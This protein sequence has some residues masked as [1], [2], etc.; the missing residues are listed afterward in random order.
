MI[1]PRCPECLSPEIEPDRASDVGRWH[2]RNCGGRFD[3]EFAFVRLREAVDFRS[4]L[5]SEPAFHLH[6]ALA[7][8]ELRALDGTIRALSPYS[9]AGELHRVL[10]AA[11]ATGVIEPLRV[12]ATL[13]AYLFPGPEPHPVLGVALGVGAELVGPEPALR[14]EE[15]EDPVAYTLRRLAQIVGVANDL[16]AG[17]PFGEVTSPQVDRTGRDG[18]RSHH[19]AP[20]SEADARYVGDAIRHGMDGRMGQRIE[21][22]GATIVGVL[23]ELGRRIEA[24]AHDPDADT[25]VV[26]SV[27]RLEDCDGTD[28][29]S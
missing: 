23:S 21:V 17:H 24:D 25:L 29:D 8:R 15:G 6:V 27:T 13:R 20:G 2:C 5:E 10:D 11:V 16:L 1:E 18:P 3:L 14:Q 19:P 26:A 4:A 9:D 12:G 7:E 28:P 22:R